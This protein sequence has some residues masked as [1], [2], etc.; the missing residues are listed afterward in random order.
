MTRHVRG[1]RER[2]EPLAVLWASEGSIYQRFGYGLATLASSIDLERERAVLVLARAGRPA[3]CGWSTSTR[4][5]GSSSRSSSATGRAI[6]GFYSRSRDVVGHRGAGRLQ[7]GAA[8]LRSQASTPSTRRDGEPDAY[9]MYRV[10]QDWANSVPGSELIVN[11]IMA[12]DGDA[13]REMWRYVFGVDLIKRITTRAGSAR[14][15]AD[16]HGRRAAPRQPAVSRDGMWLRVLDVI[17]ALERR[18]YAA[19]GSVVLEVSDEFMPERGRPFPAD[20][21]RRPRHASSA[22]TTPRTSRSTSADLGALYLGGFTLRRPRARRSNARTEPGA[23]SARRRD[24]RAPTSCRGVRRSSDHRVVAERSTRV[25]R[26]SAQSIAQDSLSRSAVTRLLVA[27]SLASSAS[28]LACPSASDDARHSRDAPCTAP[29]TSA[30]PALAGR[31]RLRRRTRHRRRSPTPSPSPPTPRRPGQR[32]QSPT[33]STAIQPD[34]SSSPS[35]WSTSSS[36]SSSPIRR[37]SPIA[38]KLLA[39]QEAPRIPNGLVVRGDPSVN[40]GWRWHIDPATFEFADVTTEVCDG[41]PVVRRGRDDHG[42]S[43]LPVERQGH[44][45]RAGQPVGRRAAAQRNA[46]RSRPARLSPPLA[47]QRS[48]TPFPW[49]LRDDQRLSAA[50]R[51]AQYELSTKCADVR[52]VYPRFI[53]TSQFH[54]A[55]SSAAR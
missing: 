22:P 48:S 28:P 50:P 42:R 45:C 38:Q 9:A 29:P 41:K 37:T 26:L 30:P 8:R 31:P 23:S 24:A 20:D 16:A 2:D 36:A 21:E 46:R 25:N 34:R 6:P 10:K 32:R 19:D 35:R 54:S 55:L 11:E 18:G 33:A 5:G 27:A 1:R 39:G 53:Q 43:L 49:P 4:P 51:A 14:R 7:V 12:V 13:L 44:R 3:P 17:A 47:N 40:T 52:S 15:A